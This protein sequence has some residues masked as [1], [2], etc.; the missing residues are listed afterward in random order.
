MT[1]KS[2]MVF[3]CSKY[4]GEIEQ[5]IENAKAYARF[6]ALCGKSP[7][8]PHLLFPQFLDDNDVEERI[9]GITLGDSCTMCCEE[10]NYI[11]VWISRE[12]IL[13]IN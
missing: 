12:C 3:C 9:K 5:N 2:N 4:R 10:C 7:V 6:I 1:R 8:V 11:Y 13:S